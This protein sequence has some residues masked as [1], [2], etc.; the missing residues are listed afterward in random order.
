[1]LDLLNVERRFKKST[2]VSAH[3]VDLYLK[4]LKLLGSHF[5]AQHEIAFYASELSV[6]TIYL[7]RVVKKITGKT[8]K[9]H[10]DRLIII[11]ASH[12]LLTTDLPIAIIAEKLN[13]A[14][15]ASFCKY[16]TKHKG[17]SPSEYRKSGSS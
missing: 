10:I 13:F 17:I 1:M 9:Y 8:V 11:E 14:N 6:T 12:L 15:P 16:F 5:A 4:F 3:V 2:D 7:S